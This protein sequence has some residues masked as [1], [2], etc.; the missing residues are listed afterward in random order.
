MSNDPDADR[1]GVRGRAWFSFDEAHAPAGVILGGAID[2]ASRPRTA[3]LTRFCFIEDHAN[4]G[5]L[6]S[7][8]SAA[9]RALA[10]G[11]MSQ[12]ARRRC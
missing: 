3:R 2:A 12:L 5:A 7:L 6:T 9:K 8:D 1:H 4:D 10:C 11:P